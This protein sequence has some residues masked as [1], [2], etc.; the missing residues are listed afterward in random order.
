MT[1]TWTWGMKMGKWNKVEELMMTLL[2]ATFLLLWGKKS[3]GPKHLLKESIKFVAYGFI[4]VESMV[5]K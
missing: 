4:E 1:G 3:P 5:V 2:S